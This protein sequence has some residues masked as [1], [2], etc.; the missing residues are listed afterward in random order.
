MKYINGGTTKTIEL[1]KDLNITA[2]ENMEKVKNIGD[3]TLGFKDD[4]GKS[5]TIKAGE[6]IECKY[7]RSMDDRLEIQKP[8]SKKKE[9]K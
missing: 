4:E 5:H 2:G 1:P 3:G 7:K 8:E 9:V 6:T